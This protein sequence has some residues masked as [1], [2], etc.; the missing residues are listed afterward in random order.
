MFVAFL[1]GKEVAS[2]LT[3]AIAFTK[4]KVHKILVLGSGGL[5]IGIRL[6]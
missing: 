1:E 3:K 4:P 2:P 5:S 6:K